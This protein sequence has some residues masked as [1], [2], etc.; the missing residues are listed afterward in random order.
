VRLEGLGQLK[1]PMKRFGIMRQNSIYCVF[2]LLF[3]DVA[4]EEIGRSKERFLVHFKD[5][6]SRK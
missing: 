4:A 3:I 1:N 5:C 6:Q 2:E